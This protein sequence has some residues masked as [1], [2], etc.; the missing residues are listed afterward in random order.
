MDSGKE[1]RHMLKAL[2]FSEKA[3]IAKFITEND[4]KILNLC[5]VPEDGRLKT[6]SFSALGNHRVLEILEFGERVDGSNLFSFIEAG[7][8][9]IYIAPRLGRAFMDPF[10]K[11]PA[12]SV[13]CDYLDENG[14]PLDVAPKNVLAKAEKKLVSSSG[15]TLKALA[16]L[17]FYIISEE[18]A[19]PLFL[20]PPDR[21]YHESSPFARFVDLR[22]EMLDTMAAMG[23][24]TKYGHSEVGQ[25]LAK[26]GVLMEQQEI[27]FAPAGLAEMAETVAI[28]KWIVR[29]VCGKYGVSVSFSPKVSVEHAGTGM[30]VHLCAVKNGR[31]M[32]ANEDGTLS[33][34][35]KKM[36]GGLLTFAPS[37][38]AFG[39]PTPVSYLR[40]IA[41]KESPMHICWSAR[42][43]LAL[44]RVPLWWSF[45]KGKDSNSC[46]ETIEY[47]ASDAFANVFL[48]FAGAALAADYGLRNSEESLRTAEE[49]H[50]KSAEQQSK[51]LGLLPR[52]CGEAAENLLKDRSLYEVDNVF[53]K[54]LVDK[55]VE[56]LKAYDD[57]GLWETLSGK[58]G[59]IEKLLGQYLHFG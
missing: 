40:F 17:E 23:I 10:S 1:E 48:L 39:N 52:S 51:K 47:R 8:S 38:S 26:D 21:N 31:N 56:K 6:L 27:E 57:V 5:H 13:L 32:I 44:I 16:E 15:M 34:E 20:N 58:P 12:L 2:R 41:R 46:R 42:N 45:K 7:K 14:K 9:D 25:L 37:L 43:R 18:K 35:A 59:E 24:V 53:P 3:E 29:N 28:G 50:V 11:L 55:T 54:K 4:V 30:H 33:S 22:N 19:R 49:L 36:I